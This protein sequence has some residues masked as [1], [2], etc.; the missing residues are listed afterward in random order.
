VDIEPCYLIPFLTPNLTDYPA[1]QAV[2]LPNFSLSFGPFRLDPTRRKLLREGKQLRLGT[3]ALDLLIALVDSGKDLISKEDLLKRVWPDTFIEEANLRVHVAALR[4]LLG[5]EAAGGQYIN[6][7]AGRGYCFVAPVTRT[8]EATDEPTRA[9]SLPEPAHHLPVSLTRVIG[10]ADSVSAISSQLTRRRFVTIIGPGGIGKTTVALAVAA[11]VADSYEHKAC[12]VELASLTDER[13]IPGALASVLGLSTLGDQPVAALV[14]HLRSKSMLMVLDN[15]EHALDAVATLAESLLKGAP[16]IHLLATSRQ[17]LRGEGEFQYHLAALAVPPGADGWSIAEALGFSAV[18]LFAERAAASLDSFELNSGNVATVID[19]CRSLDGIPL[20]I[21]LAAARVDL[22]GVEGLASRL[23]DCFSLLTK[24]RRTALPRHQTLRATLDWSFELLSEAEKIVLRR[25][26]ML[27]GEFTMEAAAALGSASEQPAADAVDT[28]S[29]LIEKSLVATDLS[30]NI[31][32]YRL[33]GT[34]RAYALEKLKLSGEEQSIAHCHAVY[35]RNLARQAEADWETVPAA[36]WLAV[37]SRA[38][39]DMRS[40]IDWAFSAD[41]QLSLGLDITI[42][43]APLWF[44]LSLMDEYRE[45]LQRAL[46]RLNESPGVDLARKARLHIA[47]GHAVWYALNDTDLMEGA[48]TRALAISEEIDDRSAQLQA[49]WGMWAVRRSRGQYRDALTVAK[50]YE[51]VA[52]DFGDAKFVSLANR[53]LSV[54][55]HC[56][57]HQD[58]A[59]SLVE[60]VQSRAPQHVRSVNNDFQLDLN[61]AMTTL[62]SRIQWLQGFPDQAAVGAREA[63]EAALKTRHVLSLGYA[64]CMAGCPVALWTGDLPEAKRCTD[65]LREH[66]AKNGL[67]S[68]WGECFEHVLRLRQGAGKDHLMAAYIEARVD[69]STLSEFAAPGAECPGTGLLTDAQPTDA[70]WSHAEVLRLEAELVLNTGATNAE[71]AVETKLLQSLDLAHA[72]SVLSFELRSAASLARLW[73]RTGRTAK[74]RSL[75]N[76]TYSRFTEGFATSDL[77]SARRLID[78]L[79]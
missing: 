40:A 43:T 46:A 75:L 34:T 22:F 3:R 58:L 53:I 52:I 33:L 56:L 26:A 9:L 67:Y 36:Q 77:L 78:E 79:G 70:L 18:E 12:F 5:D 8:E 64:L 72:Q 66:A 63:V 7:V 6:T 38:I 62:L 55:N 47:L 4:K 41:G 68:T 28:I 11:H 60:S 19:I 71:K 50:Q 23:N 37:Y 59:R 27:V 2:V 15:C 65:L 32:Q 45:R 48:F 69:V 35:F 74:A 49:L 30:A 61:V 54:N 24:G 73:Q 44:Q 42:S 76:Q 25:L 13:L 39:D 31:V 16:G 21:E 10:R 57:G 51:A 29:G 17:P 1:H 20:A 14:A